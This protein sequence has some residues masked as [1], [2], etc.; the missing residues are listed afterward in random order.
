MN[1]TEIL[2]ALDLIAAA[3]PKEKLVILAKHADD[4]EFKRVLNA[5]Y[6]PFITFGIKPQRV[7]GHGKDDFTADTWTTLSALV[8]R[9][10]VG[11]DAKGTCDKTM[12]RLNGPSAEL[13][14]RISNKDLKAGFGESTINK[15]IKNFIPE[16]PYMRCSLPKAVDL[17]S[18]DWDNGIISQVKLDGRFTNANVELTGEV[19]LTS[20]QGKAM[21]IEKFPQIAHDL[22]VRAPRGTQSH[23]E[24]LV[25]KDG[26]VL[27]RQIGNGMIEKV[28]EGGEFEEG[29]TPALQLWDNIPLSAVV[30]KGKCETPYAIRLGSLLKAFK[31][32]DTVSVAETRIVKSIGEAIEHF[33]EV[34]KRGGEGTVVKRK[35]GIWEDTGSAGSIYQV[36]I[37]IDADVE[38]VIVGYRDGKEGSK[39]ES[40][41]GA[42]VCQS[43][44]GLLEVGAGSGLKD[45]DLARFDTEEKR[46]A[47][48][49]GIATIRFND[50]M[51][52]SESNPLHSLF[53]PRVIEFRTDKTTADSL[54]T[55]FAVLAEAKTGKE[56][57]NA[58]KKK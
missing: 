20:R 47:E 1:S 7:S 51:P 2:E 56:L 22:R 3:K 11:N 32:C 10:L 17:S 31:E 8:N 57:L 39:R 29:C 15:V 36:K 33:L 16:F 12:D 14:W 23:G 46:N 42:L 43:S 50:I 54:E 13:F 38:L 49:G 26:K 30:K 44:C 4:P 45:E 27:P 24:M 19:A 28:C 35:D 18:W 6:N 25:M 52:P 9:K 48:L 55:I 37:K 41:I 5:A 53:L 34:L 21:P 58:S 40:S